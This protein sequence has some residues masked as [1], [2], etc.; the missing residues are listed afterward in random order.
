MGI[1]TIA[2]E[3]K[4]G[5]QVEQLLSNRGFYEVGRRTNAA[6]WAFPGSSAVIRISED[7][8]GSKAYFNLAQTMQ[9][10]PYMPKVYAH[11]A[12]SNGEHITL[13]ERLENPA[14]R[15]IYARFKE[16]KGAK[17]NGEPVSYADI[18]WYEEMEQT[19]LKTD[20]ISNFFSY[21]NFQM[22][23]DS[24]MPEPKAFR[25]AAV[26]IT[27]LS[28]EM[29]RANPNVYIPVPDMNHSNILWRRTS[30]GMFP[31]LYD[32]IG[33]YRN[34]AKSLEISVAQALREKLGM[35]PLAL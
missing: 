19:A 16:I 6:A 22:D 28:A 14:Q 26:A 7:V 25:E 13:V 1:F 2:A 18:S 33:T 12:L 10:N 24:V 3:R 11:T 4:T 21:S 20:T 32:P 15:E 30:G 9:H 31:I 5:F 17:Q 35:P 34:N 8:E 29:Y 23:I 27:E